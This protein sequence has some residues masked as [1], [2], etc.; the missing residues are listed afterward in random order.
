MT[1]IT[2]F[3]ETVARAREA[4]LAVLRENPTGWTPPPAQMKD[5]SWAKVLRESWP[6]SETVYVANPGKRF[7]EMRKW[8]AEKPQCTHWCSANGNAWYFED[9]KYA[10]MFKLSFGGDAQ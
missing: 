10:V 5:K 1:N 8:C 2:T 7:N 4:Y 3:R 9:R 6:E